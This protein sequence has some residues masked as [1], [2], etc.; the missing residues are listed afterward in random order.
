MKTITNKK[1]IMSEAHRIA[2]K[3]CQYNDF[4]YRKNLSIALRLRYLN[5]KEFAS[6]TIEQIN[7]IK[8]NV[9]S[10]LVKMSVQDFRKESRYIIRVD[11]YLFKVEIRQYLVVDTSWIG[12]V[13]NRNSL[14]QRGL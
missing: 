14:N 10:N 3:L 11:P 9:P 1:Y 7:F 12:S 8:N 5:E 4:S 2:K 13:I 6:H